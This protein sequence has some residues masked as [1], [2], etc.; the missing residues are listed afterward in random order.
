MEHTAETQAKYKLISNLD[1]QSINKKQSSNA[2]KKYKLIY[3]STIQ[4][5]NVNL[6]TNVDNIL[7]RNSK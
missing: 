2:D 5:D 6:Y 7:T 1:I 4:S 3:K